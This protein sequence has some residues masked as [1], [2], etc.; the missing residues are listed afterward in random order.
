M[1]VLFEPGETGREMGEMGRDETTESL[2]VGDGALELSTPGPIS[3]LP[4]SIVPL[5]FKDKIRVKTRFTKEGTY[6]ETRP[7]KP[8]L[9]RTDRHSRQSQRTREHES[10]TLK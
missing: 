8:A 3:I 1:F 9:K 4:L 6:G 7:P 2:L 5:N 10:P